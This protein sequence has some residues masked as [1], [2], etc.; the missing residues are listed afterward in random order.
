MTFFQN[1]WRDLVDKK[2]WPVAV[3]L[4]LAAVAVPVLV[5]S[6]ASSGDDV[7]AVPVPVTPPPAGIGDV[8][9]AVP[10]TTKQRSRSGAARDPFAPLVYAKTPKAPAV[11]GAPAAKSGGTVAAVASKSPVAASPASASTGTST[12]SSSAPKAATPTVSPTTTTTTST[13]LVEYA[14]ALRTKRS[15]KVTTR[16]AVR[17]LSYVPSAA[18]PLLTFLGMKKEGTV[19]TFLVR[20][21]VL[22][23]GADRVCRPSRATCRFLELKTGDDVLIAKVPPAGQ[24]IRHFRMRVGA[25][26]VVDAK[27]A[28]AADARARAF[29]NLPAISIP[30]AAVTTTRT[31]AG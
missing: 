13:K 24:D 12:T 15:G 27:K 7:A 1:L 31:T 19:A 30:M 28:T 18:Y 3:V 16:R 20:D 22:V 6:G 26:S 9:V 23:T 29:R 17:P 14:V 2:L 10:D 11:T 4:V 25:V 5:G 8:S 21:D